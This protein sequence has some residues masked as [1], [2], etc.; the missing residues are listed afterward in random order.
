MIVVFS[1]LCN[2]VYKVDLGLEAIKYEQEK[3]WPRTIH[4]KGESVWK[5]TV[6][7]TGTSTDL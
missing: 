7:C 3:V 1:F 6:K 4:V 5:Y 2:Y